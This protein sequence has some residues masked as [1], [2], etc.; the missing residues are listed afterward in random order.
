MSLWCLVLISCE[1][2]E[3]K[4]EFGPYPSMENEE[5]VT[6]RTYTLPFDGGYIY[7][8]NGNVKVML[9]FYRPD[10]L[11]KFD[12]AER[13]HVYITGTER[14]ADGES[15]ILVDKI[16]F[17][18]VQL[19]AFHGFMSSKN[20]LIEAK[21]NNIFKI[22]GNLLGD[23]IYLHDEAY[24]KIESSFID[25]PLSNV[26]SMNILYE[27]DNEYHKSV[28]KNEFGEEWMSEMEE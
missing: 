17:I 21:D 16:F 9:K 26:K 24:M 3:I 22:S 25:L 13:L 12:T 19:F 7:S 20:L 23:T 5:G 6:R 18:R 10:K 4:Y 11:F 1:H 8:E 27:Q 15:R 28:L 14:K 2:A